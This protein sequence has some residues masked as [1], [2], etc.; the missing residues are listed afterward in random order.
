MIKW[1]IY[2][3]TQFW[4]TFKLF[5]NS[6]LVQSERWRWIKSV[7]L[8]RNWGA[9]STLDQ[10]WVDIHGSRDYLLQISE[11][12]QKLDTRVWWWISIVKSLSN[13]IP[14]PAS[15]PLKS[16]H[17]VTKVFE[18][19]VTFSDTLWRLTHDDVT[20]NHQND[21]RGHENAKSCWFKTCYHT[22]VGF[23]E[24]FWSQ[25]LEVWERRNAV[26]LSLLQYLFRMSNNY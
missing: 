11:L 13:F 15:T 23:F 25:R 6:L 19:F 18:Q 1:F 24:T 7:I 16:K 8:K 5:E 9:R 20:K 14:G 21:D 12:D 4:S 22:R 3:K 17:T 10:K 2:P 26:E